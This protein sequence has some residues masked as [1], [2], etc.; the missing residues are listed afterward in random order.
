[1]MLIKDEVKKTEG[2]ESSFITNTLVKT[3]G[4]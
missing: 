4:T 1:M 2:V 3:I